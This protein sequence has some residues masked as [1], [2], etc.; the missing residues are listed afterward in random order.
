MGRMKELYIE[1]MERYGELPENFDY[2]D[3]K[4]KKDL[5]NAQWKEQQEKNERVE[6]KEK[7][8]NDAGLDG[9]CSS[10]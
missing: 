3:Y 6:R 2:Y 1:I 5:E 9:T 4:R 10:I 7:T 8:K